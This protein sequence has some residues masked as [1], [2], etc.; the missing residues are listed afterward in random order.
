MKYKQTN[1]A[2]STTLKWF[3]VRIGCSNELIDSAVWLPYQTSGI[4]VTLACSDECGDWVINS[5]KFWKM[6]N[7]E[8][9]ELNKDYD[10]GVTE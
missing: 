1:K 6:T 5:G 9:D 2:P 4:P 10:L 8:I 3:C 7:N